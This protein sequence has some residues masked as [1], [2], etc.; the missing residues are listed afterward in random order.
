V[1]T[2][3]GDTAVNSTDQMLLAIRTHKAGDTIQLGYSRNG[4]S[5]SAVV[6]VTEA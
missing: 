2:K 5:R 1:I 4:S 3:V 6:M